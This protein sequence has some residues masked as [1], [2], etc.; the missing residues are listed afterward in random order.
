MDAILGFIGF[1]IVF[2]LAYA[3]GYRR[4]E[5]RFERE[6]FY[7]TIENDYLKRGQK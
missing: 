6:L 5:I 1:A 7:K 3:L 4:A 2:I